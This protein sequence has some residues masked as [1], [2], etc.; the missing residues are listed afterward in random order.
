M[1]VLIIR[2]IL[3]VIM[4]TAKMMILMIYVA[5]AIKTVMIMRTIIRVIMI[6]SV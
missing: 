6:M 5:V 1:V 2:T 4:T 3:T